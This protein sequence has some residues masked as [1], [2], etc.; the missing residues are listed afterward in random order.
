ML[1]LSVMVGAD[2]AF[3]NWTLS[4]Y[5]ANRRYALRMFLIAKNFA[6]KVASLFQVRAFAPA[7]A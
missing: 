6:S 1:E 3:D 5:F 4:G 7:V 2:I